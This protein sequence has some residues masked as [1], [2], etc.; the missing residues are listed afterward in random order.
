MYFHWKTWYLGFG[1]LGSL[2]RKMESEVSIN[3]RAEDHGILKQGA[4]QSGTVSYA[5][6][7]A[8]G[9]Y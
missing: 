7:G 8:R 4:P 6:L 9:L 2:V 1:K 3:M 5:V